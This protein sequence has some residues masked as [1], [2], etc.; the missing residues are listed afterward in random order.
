MAFK[1]KLVQNYFFHYEFRISKTWNS[2]QKTK[3][4]KICIKNHCEMQ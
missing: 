3:K 2:S 4:K 1:Y